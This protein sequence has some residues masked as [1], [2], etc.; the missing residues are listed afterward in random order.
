MLPSLSFCVLSA[1][2][3]RGERGTG[4][5][6]V[7]KFKALSH[8]TNKNASKGNNKMRLEKGIEQKPEDFSGSLSI[9]PNNYS[10]SIFFF[11]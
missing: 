11:F 6:V 4:G 8:Q 3:L 1:I 9:N 2:N 10:S 7:C 5:M